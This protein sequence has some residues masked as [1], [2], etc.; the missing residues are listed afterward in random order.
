QDRAS[1]AVGVVLE[2]NDGSH[3]DDIVG[4]VAVGPDFCTV[5]LLEQQ[6]GGEGR[7]MLHLQGEGR[8]LFGFSISDDNVRARES[9]CR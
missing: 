3:A 2:L 5:D 6:A 1:G 8:K 9:F 7:G 4:H